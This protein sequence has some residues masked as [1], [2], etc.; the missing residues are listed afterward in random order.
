MIGDSIVGVDPH[1]NIHIQDAE[2]P[3]TKGLWE[4]LTR[5][6][7]KKINTAD[8]LQRYKTILEMT[9]AHLEGYNPNA[10]INVSRGLKFRD[11][12]S[13]L[14]PGAPQRSVGTPA[15]REW[16]SY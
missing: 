12:I 7:V 2:F 10:N 15:R 3:G 11:V 8:D 4:V 14:F 6:G 16:I 5:K 9:N 13:K 1:I